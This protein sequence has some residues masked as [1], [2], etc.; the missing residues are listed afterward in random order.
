MI[1]FLTR[2]RT[3]LVLRII[4]YYR[5]VAQRGLLVRSVA[6]AMPALVV[7]MLFMV[8]TFAS[9]MADQLPDQLVALS[10]AAVLIGTHFL[11]LFEV[12]ARVGRGEGMAAALYQYPV[13]PQLIHAAEAITGALTPSMLCAV[14]ALLAMGGQLSSGSLLVLPSLLCVVLYLLGMRQLLQLGVALLLRRRWLREAAL[15]LLSTSVLVAWFFVNWLAHSITLESLVDRLAEAP[16]IFWMLPFHW[17]TASWVDFLAGEPLARVVALV[18]APLLVV[19]VAVVGAD[20]QD[21]ACFGEGQSLLGGGRRTGRIRAPGLLDRLPFSWVSAATWAT[22][23]KEI[24][25]MRRDPFF[26]VMFLT[27][28]VILL[29]SPIV[30]PMMFG[31]SPGAGMGSGSGYLPLFVFLLWM[32]ESTPLFNVIAMEGRALHFLAQV[33][34]ARHQV[35]LGKNLGYFVVFVGLNVAFLSVA[36]WILDGTDVL[37]GCVLVSVVGLLPLIGVGNLCSV[38]LPT[39][40]IGAR[41]AA[42]GHRAAA[43]AAEGGVENPGCLVP[44]LRFLCLQGVLILVLPV[45]VAA[46]VAHTLLGP[47]GWFPVSLACVAYGALIYVVTTGWAVSSLDRAEGQLLERFA[48]RGAR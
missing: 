19:S 24:R 2:L 14:A 31:D 3:L 46:L 15:A 28:G 33:P 12:V 43:Q 23:G 34:V 37:P 4:L 30:L 9:M 20:L 7:W 8:F 38:F 16:L 35:L 44:V 32:V 13:S 48:S 42:G 10:F 39:A 22:M 25:V 26:V 11:A 1:E 21:R 47:W 45:A 17:F 40:W 29:V 6:Y 18:G 36:A 41:A 5:R 27:Q